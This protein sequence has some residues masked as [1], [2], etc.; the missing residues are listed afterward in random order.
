MLFNIQEHELRIEGLQ[1]EPLTLGTDLS[2]AEISSSIIDYEKGVCEAC[3]YDPMFNIRIEDLQHNYS[4]D[5][6]KSAMSENSCALFAARNELERFISIN[7]GL[8]ESFTAEL[9]RRFNECKETLA[10]AILR[11]EMLRKA[12]EIK[13]QTCGRIYE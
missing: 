9:Q 2:D 5:E 11:Q 1:K 4:L 13:E 12:V 10:N 6:L 3:E 8:T 7:T